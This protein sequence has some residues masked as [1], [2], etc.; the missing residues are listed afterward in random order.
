MQPK[1]KTVIVFQNHSHQSTGCKCTYFRLLYNHESRTRTTEV[2]VA[3]VLR[4]Y[5]I[6]LF[7]M[8]MKKGCSH[9]FLYLQIL[10]SSRSGVQ[11]NCPFPPPQLRHWHSTLGAFIGT[12]QYFKRSYCDPQLH[13]LF[14]C[15]KFDILLPI[16]ASC[17]KMFK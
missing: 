11:C 15:K 8:D 3:H 9:I 17:Y 5:R 13:S 1:N 6:F 2:I 10:H 14:C 12:K 4:A 7:V 16:V